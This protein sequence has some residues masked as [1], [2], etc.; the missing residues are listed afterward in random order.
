MPLGMTQP[1]TIAKEVRAY[2]IRKGDPELVRKYAKFFTEGYDAYGLD[3]R[4]PEWD[5]NRKAWSGRLL[6]AAPLAFLDAGDLLVHTGKYEEASFAILF[7]ADALDRATPE[8]LPR[9][10]CW[11]DGG[12]RNWAHTDVLCREVLSPL[13]KKGAIP[14][15][16]LRDWLTSP[17]K[18]QRRA[19]PVALIPL[20]DGHWELQALFDLVEQLM[21]D[22]EKPVQQ[23]AGWFLREA[24]KRHPEP[25]EKLLL[26]YKDRAPRV[27]YQYAT[28]KMTA[29][30]KSRFRKKS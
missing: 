17:H 2:C 8:T 22:P 24:W 18:F 21:M 4:D 5:A 7:A 26:H 11:F 3:Y 14:I 6:A 9:I 20:L 12:I 16:S 19:V 25:T 1:R 10:A 28:E 15:D 27:I 30:Q 29:A 23:G 13:L